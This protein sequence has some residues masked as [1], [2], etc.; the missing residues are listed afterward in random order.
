MVTATLWSVSLDVFQERLDV[1]IKIVPGVT[2][3][4][5][6]IFGQGRQ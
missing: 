1:V 6:N 2:G 4:A 5:D 3:I